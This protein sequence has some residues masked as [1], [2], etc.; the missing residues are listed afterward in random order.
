MNICKDRLTGLLPDI[1]LCYCFVKVLFTFRAQ[2]I[3]APPALK[4][5][6]LFKR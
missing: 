4:I 2:G 3:L 1:L 6:P 5:K